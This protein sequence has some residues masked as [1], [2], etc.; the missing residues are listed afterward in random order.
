MLGEYFGSQ[1]NVLYSTRLPYYL[2]EDKFQNW[3]NTDLNVSLDKASRIANWLK[4]YDSSQVRSIVKKSLRKKETLPKE[5]LEQEDSDDTSDSDCDW[6]YLQKED[7]L[8]QMKQKSLPF[9]NI[10]KIVE[11]ALK[12]AGVSG[13][14]GDM[15]LEENVSDI[16]EEPED[17]PES[18]IMENQRNVANSVFQIWDEISPQKMVNGQEASKYYLLQ[19]IS[20][21]DVHDGTIHYCAWDDLSNEL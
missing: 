1:A 10:E 3:L 2:G 9:Q 16:N 20:S 14:A 15:A 6:P 21:N 7:L 13:T 12:E 5:A 4:L 8:H 18:A 17:K 11:T 19:L